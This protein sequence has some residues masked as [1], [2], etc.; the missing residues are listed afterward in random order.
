MNQDS[1]ISEKEDLF[2]D[3]IPH[4]PATTGQRFLNWLIDNL[5]MRFWP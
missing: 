1:I 2:E 3:Y 5:L 4:T